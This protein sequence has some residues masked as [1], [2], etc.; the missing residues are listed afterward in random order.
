MKL[1][2][3][4]LTLSAALA[5]A[6]A[7]S[8]PPVSAAKSAPTYHLVRKISLPGDGGWDYLTADP[9]NHRLFIT[10]GTHVQVVDTKTGTLA[11]DIGPLGGVHGVA[12]APQAGRGFISDGKADSIAVFDTKTLRLLAPINAGTRPDAIIYDPSTRRVFAFNGGSNNSTAID[13]ATQTVA[14][15]I[16]LGGR[17]EDAVADGQGHVYVNL[18]DK[19]QIVEIDAKALTVLHTWPLAPGTSPS[20]L[21]IDA[22]NRRLFSVCDNNKMVVMDADTGAIIATPAI[23]NGPDACA[24]DPATRLAFSPNGEDSTLTLVHEDSPRA[25]TVVGTVTTQA[26]ARTF[27]LDLKTHHI[28]SV[29]ATPALT[30]PDP[31]HPRRRSYVPG[32]FVL[33]EYAP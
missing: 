26:G 18:E 25:F 7:L 22:K 8:P 29:T 3:R 12:L 20:G 6:F 16:A 24:F 33:L 9:D 10:R 4:I 23:G 1:T 19:S 28:F 14:G 13:S 21:A 31:A 32:S 2:T 17:P 27:A 11:G 30:A 15:T 5:A